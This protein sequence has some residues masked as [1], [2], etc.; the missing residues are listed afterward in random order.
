MALVS[1][2]KFREFWGKKWPVSAVI[3]VV[4]G[5]V[6]SALKSRY[7]WALLSVCVWWWH[8][9]LVKKCDRSQVRLNHANSSTVNY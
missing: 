6:F 9:D 1:L 3:L 8:A 7:K 5:V 2:S 4:F